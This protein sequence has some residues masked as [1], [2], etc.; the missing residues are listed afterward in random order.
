MKKSQALFFMS[1]IIQNKT[2]IDNVNITKY[3]ENIRV[4]KYL[5]TE[6]KR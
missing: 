5:L 6:K 3:N 4:S 1:I 2:N